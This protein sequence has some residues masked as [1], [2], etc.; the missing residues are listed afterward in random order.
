MLSCR[1]AV[2]SAAMREAR[3]RSPYGDTLAAPPDR[4]RPRG[5]ARETRDHVHVQLRHDVAERGDVELVGMQQRFERA[6]DAG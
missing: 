2:R 5:V 3:S 1:S 4:L 6:A